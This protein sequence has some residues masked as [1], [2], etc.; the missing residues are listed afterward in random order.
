M[1]LSE[2]QNRRQRRLG[3]EHTNFQ[4]QVGTALR[5]EHD[6]SQVTQNR[7]RAYEN[8]SLWKVAN[9]ADQRVLDA[10]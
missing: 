8:S 3:M 5:Y 1:V 9:C 4:A 2:S 7:L 10:D 6:Q